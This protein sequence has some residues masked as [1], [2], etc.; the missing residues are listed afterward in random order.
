MLWM[1]CRFVYMTKI[2]FCVYHIEMLYIYDGWSRERFVYIWWWWWWKL[3]LENFRI[4]IGKF[5]GDRDEVFEFRVNSDFTFFWRLHIKN[6]FF[7]CVTLWGFCGSLNIWIKWD[8]YYAT[9]NIWRRRK[10]H[11]RLFISNLKKIFHF[12]F[13]L[14]VSSV[15]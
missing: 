9:N 1:F 7:F 2:W 3:V 13:T 11:V 5:N 4:L 10:K 8:L 15:I 6:C 12:F 14:G